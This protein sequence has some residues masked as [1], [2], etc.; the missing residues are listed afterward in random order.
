M[1]LS[2]GCGHPVNLWSRSQ[3]QT[4][5][6]C[7]LDRDSRRGRGLVGALV[8]RHPRQPETDM[9][10]G[11]WLVGLVWLGLCAVG[12]N[13]VAPA[14]R[15]EAVILCPTVTANLPCSGQ[16]AGWHKLDGGLD[17]QGR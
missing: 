17:D 14:T 5:H 12:C 15:G 8:L 4:P 16:S 10:M 1:D 11:G 3:H 2:V 9:R 13:P 7:E 6:V